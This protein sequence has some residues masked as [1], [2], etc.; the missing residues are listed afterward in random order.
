[1]LK[2]NRPNAA[3]GL[4]QRSWCHNKAQYG[5]EVWYNS[6]LETWIALKLMVRRYVVR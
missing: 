5:I 4:G 2:L 3:I 6:G 1:M